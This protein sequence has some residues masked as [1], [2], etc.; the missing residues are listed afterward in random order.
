MKR[1][2]GSVVFVLL[3]LLLPQG[4][5][6]GVLETYV[7]ERPTILAF[8]PP[9]TEADLAKDEGTNEALGDF[10][11]YAMQAGPKLKKAG[12]DFEVV[13]A[14]KFKIKSGKVFR[15]FSSG[16]IGIGYYFVMPGKKPLV[17]YGVMTDD[18]ILEV[19][20]KYFGVTIGG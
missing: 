5:S 15:T 12:I 20:G 14:V 4:G 3:L 11:F 1:L 9:V 13:S 16:K 8:F 17:R 6:Q 2:I 7:V 18:E 19:G 10:Q